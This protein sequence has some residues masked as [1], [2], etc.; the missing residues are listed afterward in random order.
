MKIIGYMFDGVVSD[1]LLVLPTASA[2]GICEHNKRLAIR[3]VVSTKNSFMKKIFISIIAVATMLNLSSCSN[4]VV[5]KPSSEKAIVFDNI[6][7]R[8]LVDSA[9]EILSMGVFAQMNLGGEDEAGSNSYIMLLENEH[10]SRTGSSAPWT[11]ENTRYWVADRAYHFFAVWP[12]SEDNS[13]VTDVKSVEGNG[14]YGYSV[15]FETPE[16]A[17]QELLT[18]KKTETTKDE[19][20]PESVALDFQHE[21]T[22][23]NLKIWSNGEDENKNDQI[24]VK[25]VTLS[26]VAKK[27]TLNTTA[28]GSSSWSL[29]SEKMTFTKQYDGDGITVSQAK[30]NANGQLETNG[31]NPGIPFGEG[32]LLIPHTITNSAPVVVTVIYDLQRPIDQQENSWETKK[33][34]V[35]LPEGTWPAGKRLTY[36]LVLS[37]ERTITDFQINTV[38]EDWMTQT[39]EID[40]TQQVEVREEEKMRWVEGTYESINVPNGEVVLYTDVDKVAICEF[41]IRTPIGATWTAS[42]IPLTA[43][44]MDAFSIV[45]DSKYG[46]VGTDDMQRVKIKINNPDPISA[47]NECLLRITVQTSDGR[48]I[49]VKNLMPKEAAANNIEEFKIIQ[50]LING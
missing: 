22:N 8:G 26:N 18:A 36:N 19:Y 39:E 28:D 50:N 37:G 38:V 48:T 35:F 6:E 5:D 45:E 49:V 10:V 24:R 34:Q 15:T 12:Y 17:D 33:L 25:S 44:A 14:A 13:C 1:S 21:L 23:V 11:Y 29:S 46:V 9:D 3:R 42:L 32:L 7:T 47:R 43:S 27:G 16:A 40:F 2:D 30:I 20:F 4:E 41:N 31:N